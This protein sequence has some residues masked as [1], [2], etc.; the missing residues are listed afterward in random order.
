MVFAPARVLVIASMLLLGNL[1]SPSVQAGTSP[2][3][4]TVRIGVGFTD[5]SPKQLVRTSDNILYAVVADCQQYPC[6]DIAQTIHVYEGNQSGV[7]TSFERKDQTHEPAA[8]AGVACAIDG[9][10]NIHIVWTARSSQDNLRYLRYAIFDT[11]TGTWGATTT[12]ADNLNFN[13]AGQGDQMV[14]IALDANA[15]PHVIYLSGRLPNRRMYY[16]NRVTG[17]WSSPV[18]LDN[19]VSYTNNQKAWHPNLAFDT[20]GHILVAWLRGSF[21]GDNDG[22]IFVRVRNTNGTWGT[23]HNI[24][25]DNT[26]RVSIDQSTSLLITPDNRF[27]I[28]FITSPNDYVRYAYSDDQGST[29]QFNNPGGGTQVT[30]NPSLG[31]G[32]DGELRIY[33]H[34][35]PSPSPDG[36]GDNIY[37]FEGKGGDA[38]WSSFTQIVSGS[39]D[40]SVNTRWSQYFNTNTNYLDFAYWSD[41]YPN[42]AFVSIQVSNLLTDAAPELNYY[43]TATPTLTWNRVS[44]AARYELQIAT[45][46]TFADAI[47]YSVINALAFTLPI[48][49]KGGQYFWRVRACST[50]AGC[51]AWS[52]AENIIIGVA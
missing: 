17:S 36:H 2:E 13:D 18:R 19:Q 1:V 40:S 41:D 12:I 16:Q 14:A 42:E 51:G 34:G 49:L 10:D 22:T 32:P 3:I 23:T 38:A 30:H 35:T 21:N 26:A 46:T 37:Y 4:A 11:H 8:V 25:G 6:K 20:L 7:P 5:V 24:S 28:T 50:T 9:D 31:P 43:I 47:T 52:G 33:A 48:G 27:H 29:W 45:N 44:W 15:N 39:F